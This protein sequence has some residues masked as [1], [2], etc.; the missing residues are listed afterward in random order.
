MNITPGLINYHRHLL[1]KAGISPRKP[2][3]VELL[4]EHD[5]SE[6]NAE[7]ILAAM[8]APSRTR[9]YDVRRA[10]R[11]WKILTR[12]EHGEGVAYWRAAL[13]AILFLC[14]PRKKGSVL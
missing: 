1:Q 7:A 10:S 3:A 5:W 9:H 13:W 12:N 11:A 4:K 6:E 14:K 8:T 2:E